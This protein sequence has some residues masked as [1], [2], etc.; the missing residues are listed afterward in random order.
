MK[1]EL[2]YIELK[3]GY[4][5][6]GPAWIGM[7]EF[8]K[9]GRTIYFNGKAFAGNG[10]GTCYDVETNERYWI[11]GIKKTAS[12]RHWAGRRSAKI[13]IDRQVVDDYLRIKDFTDLDLNW[14]EKVDI[15]PTDKQAFV[16][17]ENSSLSGKSS[18]FRFQNSRLPSPPSGP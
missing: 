18:R 13:M 6:D 10:H 17:I 7:V 11:T 2:K 9:T 1:S 3:S 14:Y 12:N 16:T 5:D 8:S 4:N 15:G